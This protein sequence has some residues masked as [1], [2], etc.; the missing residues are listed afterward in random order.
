M[1][2]NRNRKDFVADEAL[3]RVN[4]LVYSGV[5]APM[6]GCTARP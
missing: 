3:R 6:V 4:G 5:E 2:S 1:E